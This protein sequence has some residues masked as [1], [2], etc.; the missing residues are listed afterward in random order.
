ML[1]VQVITNNELIEDNLFDMISSL[2]AQPI[3]L[4]MDTCWESLE[5]IPNLVLID[6]SP[7]QISPEQ[8]AIAIH[9]NNKGCPVLL[10]GYAADLSRNGDFIS[11]KEN[12]NCLFHPYPLELFKTKI[13]KML[14][15]SR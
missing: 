8:L 3:V 5:V 12:F 1:K 13:H 7:L 14:G 4:P 11:N 6:P 10:H 2:G 9:F 15:I